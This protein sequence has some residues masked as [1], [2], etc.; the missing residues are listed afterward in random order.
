MA[1][2]EIE[3]Q[4]PFEFAPLFVGDEDGRPVLT[5]IIK[6]TYT[7]GEDGEL[8]L[9]EKQ[10]PV[11]FAGEHHGEPGKSSLKYE[12]ETAFTKP[13]TDVVLIGHAQA[14]HADTT[15][16]H[17]TL[18]AGP[19]TK[20]VR[21]TGD[22][23]WE[24]G[25]FGPRISDPQPFLKIPLVWERAYGGWDTSHDKPEKHG[26]EPRNPVGVGFRTKRA[27]LEEGAPLPNLEDPKAPL[28][29][30]RGRSHPAGF[31][32]VSPNWEPRASLAGTY[33][34]AWEKT[35]MPLLAADFQRRFFNAAPEDL[36]APSYL[37]GDE[38]VFVSNVT[39][40]GRL[41]FALPGLAPPECL[42]GRRDAEDEVLTTHLDTVIIN[43]DEMRLVLLWR[44]FTTLWEGP[45]DV[46]SMRIS[47]ENAPEARSR[48]EPR[49]EPKANV[50]P[51]FSEGVPTPP[52]GA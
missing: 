44:T 23:R 21:V 29:K 45:L 27:K 18:K 28:T 24:K 49:E 31:G 12:P 33:D 1:H 13:G 14:R 20:T 34:K 37:R 15:E 25:L 11:S 16:V 47:C 5:P 3:N 2:P 10:L 19:L 48:E 43:T 52:P 32:F 6:A 22:R 40:E 9:A 4:T 35:R 8:D 50:V 38:P 17:V 7:I 42:V 46:R 41:A 26:W 51:L 39:P 30:Y 36:I